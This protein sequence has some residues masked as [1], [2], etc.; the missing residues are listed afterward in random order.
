LS[1]NVH[2]S[3]GLSVHNQE[4]KTVC[5]ATGISKTEIPEM[6]NIY[7]TKIKK[8]TNSLIILPTSGISD[9]HVPVAV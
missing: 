3:D 2:V 6:G 4:L 5:T 9:L 1:N 8:Y 7:N